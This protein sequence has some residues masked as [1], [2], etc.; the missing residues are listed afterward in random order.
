[1]I[2]AGDVGGTKVHLALYSFEAGRLK[3]I[4]DA[5]FPATQFA[6]LDAVVNHYDS[7]MNLGL[8]SQEKSDL[9]QYLKSLPNPEE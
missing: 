8:S 7:C 6:T 2:L 3:Q 1:M 9:V 5:K 4:R